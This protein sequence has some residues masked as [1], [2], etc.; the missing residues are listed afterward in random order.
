MHQ[1]DSLCSFE[2][3]STLMMAHST[4]VED[5]SIPFSRDDNDLSQVKK[6]LE[7]KKELMMCR[8]TIGVLQHYISVKV[9]R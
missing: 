8:N 4:F 1:T 6:W 2:G 9:N 3:S 5:E 7:L